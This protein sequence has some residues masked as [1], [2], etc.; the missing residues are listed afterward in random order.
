MADSD[1]R[2]VNMRLTEK[3]IATLASWG[4][5]SITAGFRL[6]YSKVVGAPAKADG[7]I[8]ASKQGALEVSVATRQ[9]ITGGYIGKRR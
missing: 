1:T 5:G 4:N 8:L 2:Q 7:R 9:P 3:E 6:M